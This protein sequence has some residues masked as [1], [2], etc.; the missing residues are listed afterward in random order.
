M[1]VREGNG[2]SLVFDYVVSTERPDDS[3]TRLLSHGGRQ[4]DSR[5]CGT[6]SCGQCE[7]LV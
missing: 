6:K 7:A 1:C 4:E 2:D 5:A 3:T